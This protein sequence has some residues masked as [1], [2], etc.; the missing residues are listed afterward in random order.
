V[1]RTRAENL[2]EGL[3]I[4]EALWRRIESGSVLEEA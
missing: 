1:L 2:A 3:P 4:E